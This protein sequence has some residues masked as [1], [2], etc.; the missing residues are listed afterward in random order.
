MA[1]H[2]TARRVFPLVQGV[3]TINVERVRSQHALKSFLRRVPVIGS[4]PILTPERVQ[5]LQGLYEAGCVLSDL[6]ASVVFCRFAAFCL[7]PSAEISWCI[8][9]RS[10]SIS[11]QS[12]AISEKLHQLGLPTHV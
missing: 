12:N 10:R 5:C 4:S 7:F 8:C 2:V 3:H 9:L 11:F 6:T 1:V